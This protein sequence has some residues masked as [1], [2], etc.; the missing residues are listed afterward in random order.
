[1]GMNMDIALRAMDVRAAII[2]GAPSA[3]VP[4]YI[5]GDTEK[6]YGAIDILGLKDYQLEIMKEKRMDI[7]AV[8]VPEY[9]Y[10]LSDEAIDGLSITLDIPLTSSEEIKN[11]ISYIRDNRIDALI[12]S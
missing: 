8:P 5:S 7:G 10:D 9:I 4:T 2:M 11:F 6:I 1:M 12:F 3:S